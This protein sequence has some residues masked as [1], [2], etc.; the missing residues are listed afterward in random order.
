[1]SSKDQE[2]ALQF[3]LLEAKL[4]GMARQREMVANRMSEIDATIAGIEEISKAKDEVVFHV[5]GEAFM[6]ARPAKDAKM[7]VMIG[8]EVAVEKTVDESKAL[9]HSRRKEAEDVMK[10]LEREIEGVT[11]QLEEMMP[12]LDSGRGQ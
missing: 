5:G 9:L 12:T 7:I 3:R 2:A 10:H 8:A 4:E 11:K 6:P 1:M